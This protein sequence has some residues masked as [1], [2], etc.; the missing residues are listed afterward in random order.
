[1][2]FHAAYTGL[3]RDLIH[4]LKFGGRLHLAVALGCLLAEHPAFNPSDL[5][6][7]G[8]KQPSADQSSFSPPS[9]DQISL[10]QP[11]LGQTGRHHPNDQTPLGQPNYKQSAL[12][13]P[14]FG[15]AGYHKPSLAQDGIA[16][17]PGYDCITP[18]PLHMSRLSQ[19]GFN[20]SAEIAR[21]LAARLGIPICSG[22]LTRNT[23]TRRQ[24]GLT[25]KERAQN[26]RGVFTAPPLHG[27]RILLLD[28]IMTTG[29]TLH[30]AATCLLKA[31]AAAVDI[32]VIAR[33]PAR[34]MCA[35]L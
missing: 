30:E 4:Q 34:N 32:A 19:R 17:A 9:A 2:Y 22:L 33:T 10:S 6:H 18:I 26:L 14:A 7:T 24:S 20:Q 27:Q 12:A 8:F 1:M 15:Q 25:R 28:D 35:E 16:H 21:P 13:L 3:L 11:A 23:A 31:G 5:A 29:A